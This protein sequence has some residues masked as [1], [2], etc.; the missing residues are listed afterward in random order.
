[1][2]EKEAKNVDSLLNICFKKATMKNHPIVG[3]P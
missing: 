3:E 2:F 1:L